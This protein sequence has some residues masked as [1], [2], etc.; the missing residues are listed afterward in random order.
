MYGLGC[1]LYELLTSRRPFEIGEAP[2]FEQIQKMLEA[3]SPRAPSQVIAADAPISARRLRGDLDTIVLKALKRD[4]QRRYATVDALSADLRQ[5]ISGRP[6]A[7]RRDDALYRMRKFVGRHRL[8][9]A[10]T[11]LAVLALIASTGLAVWQARAKAREAQA[12]AEVTRF[13]TDLFQG[14]DPTLAR[15][16]TVTAQDL[17]GSGQRIACARMRVS[18]LPCAPA[19][20]A[21]DRSHLHL[22]RLVR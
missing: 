9:V 6:I 21:H 1:V 8:G 15:G 12:S 20:V 13:L 22:A 14:A 11:T 17:L 7:A 5:F 19:P 16:A 18:N 4:P 10:I 3:T 2:T